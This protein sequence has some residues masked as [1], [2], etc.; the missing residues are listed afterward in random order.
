MPFIR[1]HI[2]SREGHAR[3]FLPC[4]PPS[5]AHGKQP[6]R[7]CSVLATHSRTNHPHPTYHTTAIN[8]HAK[9]GNLSLLQHAVRSAAQD[10]YELNAVNYT[11][12]ANAH[13]EHGSP[14]QVFNV[15]SMMRKQQIPPT[16]V[17]LRVAI[18]A[19]QK[20]RDLRKSQNAIL[21]SLQWVSSAHIEPC[22]RSWNLALGVLAK[23]GAYR[24]VGETVQWMHNAEHL[25]SPD[26]RSYNVYISSYKRSTRIREAIDVFRRMLLGPLEIRP[27]VVTYNTLLDIAVCTDLPRIS[28]DTDEAPSRFV[29]AILGSM[30]RQRVKPNLTTETLILRVLSRKE[31]CSP[32]PQFLWTRFSKLLETNSALADKQ[33]SNQS[34]ETIHSTQALRPFGSDIALNENILCVIWQY[35]DAAIIGFGRTSDING[36]LQ[37][38]SQMIHNELQPD[39]YTFKALLLGSSYLGDVG[40]A[41]SILDVLHRNCVTLDANLFTTAIAS[42]ARADPRDPISAESLLHYAHENGIKWTSAMINAAISSW[43]DDSVGAIQSWQKLRTCSDEK[44]RKALHARMVYDALMRV[45]GRQA[46]PDL[47]LRIFYA[48]KKAGHVRGNSPNSRSLYNAFRRGS[49]ESGVDKDIDSNILKRPYVHHLKAEC[50]VQNDIHL[51]VERIRIK[52]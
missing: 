25:P 35:L 45:C 16:N 8:K 6:Q 52:L 36:M 39:N 29:D 24:E 48:A 41:K 50:G 37:A 17:T 38:F 13:A 10:G 33:V 2:A 22:L 23:R 19:C 11:T 1:Y 51:P 26:T 4:P 34:F 21:E 27:D 43:G 47:A 20:W 12:I 15:L 40:L 5:T 49:R 31:A 18:K 42:C 14:Q 7:K 3:A 30:A 46:R 44:S 28:Q 32:D 9:S